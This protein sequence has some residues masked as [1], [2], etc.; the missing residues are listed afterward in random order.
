MKWVVWEL[1]G[2][3]ERLAVLVPFLL[4]HRQPLDEEVGE[5]RELQQ[6]RPPLGR[7]IGEHLQTLAGELALLL[8][9][10]HVEPPR[11]REVRSMHTRSIRS[12]AARD[13]RTKPRVSNVLTAPAIALRLAKSASA[14]SPMLCSRGQHTIR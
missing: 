14:S 8:I 12:P 9:L 6:H 11:R 4:Q 5:R 13:R 1:T 3:A 2:V 7:G 10:R